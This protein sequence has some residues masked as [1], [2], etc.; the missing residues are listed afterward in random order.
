MHEQQGACT[1]ATAIDTAHERFETHGRDTTAL[2]LFWL[3]ID[4]DVLKRKARRTVRPRPAR[5]LHCV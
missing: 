3:L 1:R 2:R 4:I 5:Y